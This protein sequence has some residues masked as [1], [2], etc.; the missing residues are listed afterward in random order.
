MLQFVHPNPQMGLNLAHNTR[1][2]TLSFSAEE[3]VTV[4]G[5]AGFFDCV[6]YKEVTFSTVPATHSPGMFSWFPL[7]VPLRVPLRVR[8]GDPIT[9]SVWRCV[10]D[11]KVWYE[12][13]LSQPV[14]TVIQNSGGV[15]YHVKL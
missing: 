8:K 7:F 12:W 10:G 14:A 5:L 1:Y 3:S 2:A 11:D 9:V 15:S 4:H 13:C 6:L